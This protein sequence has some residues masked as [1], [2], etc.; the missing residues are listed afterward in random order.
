VKGRKKI[1]LWDIEHYGYN[2]NECCYEQDKIV[3]EEIWKLVFCVM[4]IG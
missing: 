3:K 2:N 1:G 4:E